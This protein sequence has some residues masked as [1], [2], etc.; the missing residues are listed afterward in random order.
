M[1]RLLTSESIRNEAIDSVIPTYLIQGETKSEM[2]EKF[3]GDS[4]KLIQFLRDRAFE[5]P[6]KKKPKAIKAGV[7]KEMDEPPP[8]RKARKKPAP[9]LNQKGLF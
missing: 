2:L 7:R 8:K 3:N 5:K 4:V 6:K 9:D 1:P